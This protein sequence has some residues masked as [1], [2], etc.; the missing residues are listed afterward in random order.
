MDLIYN[1]RDEAIKNA[2]LAFERS[3]EN[4]ILE[5]LKQHGF[6]FYTVDDLKR[7]VAD[8]HIVASGTTKNVF[9]KE[10]L[11]CC[12]IDE[13]LISNDNASF[14]GKILNNSM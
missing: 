2:V 7:N 14:K 9:Y 6:D 12:F 11:I 4:F 8:F 3:K 1:K 13:P 10:K 5:A